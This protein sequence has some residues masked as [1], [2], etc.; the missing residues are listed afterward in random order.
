MNFNNQTVIIPGKLAECDFGPG[1]QDNA[2][3][4]TDDRAGIV[5]LKDVYKRQTYR[6]YATKLMSA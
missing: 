3:K 2:A 6:R 4:V 5:V 1:S